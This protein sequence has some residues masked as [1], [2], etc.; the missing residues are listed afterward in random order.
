MKINKRKVI[1]DEFYYQVIFLKQ[2][3]RKMFFDN[4]IVKP[5]EL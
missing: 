5:Q 2:R 3:Q 1:W 4:F